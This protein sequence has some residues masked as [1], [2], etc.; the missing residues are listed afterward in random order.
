MNSLRTMFSLVR[1]T[2]MAPPPTMRVGGRYTQVRFHQYDPQRVAVRK[3]HKGRVPIRTGGSTKG[4]MLE[5]GNYGLRLLSD[6]V[7]ISAK[8]MK[9]AE[10]VM[11]RLVRPLPG[12]SIFP[13]LTTN[14]AV[15][16]KGNETRM[17]KGKGPFDY[18]AVRVA[19]GKILLELTGEIHE[20]VAKQA[21]K[22]AAQKLPGKYEVVTKKTNTAMMGFIKTT[23][24]PVENIFEKLDREPTKDWAIKQKGKSPSFKCFRP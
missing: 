24:A 21:F 13:R 5:F 7:R 20:Q 23:P 17:G 8:Q 10:N 9:E 4:T 2:V 3:Q 18:W 16:T 19:T 6:G 22:L 12:V 1:R 15:C 11:M 14:V